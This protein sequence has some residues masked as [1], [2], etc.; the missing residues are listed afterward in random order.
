MIRLT[1][2]VFHD[3]SIWMMGLGLIIGIVFPFFVYWMGIPA[4]YVFKPWFFAV[5]ILAGLIVGGF[6]I[7]L[8]RSVVGTR[9]RILADRMQ[10][11]TERF[12]QVKQGM[13]VGECNPTEC[14]V[15]VDSEDEL[16]FSARA[17]NTLVETLFESL[18]TEDSI[19]RFNQ[20]LGT[21]FEVKDLTEKA[22]SQLM[23]HTGSAAGAV[24]IEKGGAL[25]VTASQGIQDVQSLLSNDHLKGVLRSESRLILSLPKDIQVD[26]VLAKFTPREVIIEPILFKNV[27]L[28]LLILGS[29]DPFGMDAKK[30][31]GL[32]SQNLAMALHNALLFDRLERLAALDSLTGIYNRRFGLTRLHEEF[33][34]TLRMNAPLGMM[35]I[36]LDHFKQVND[37]FG[38]LTG[39]RVLIRLANAAKSVMREG[40][41]LVRYGGEEFLAILPGASWKDV[42]EI[43]DRLRRKIAETSVQHGE[44]VIKVTVSV[45]GVSYPELEV[46]DEMELVD[47]ADKALYRAKES[48]RNCVVMAN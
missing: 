2:K 5:C 12:L 45:G 41:V 40:D 26:G 20:L 17:F 6:N 30:R 18:E 13:D 24:L 25:E 28:G 9:L 11:V 27:M 46:T 14:M 38:H 21:Q 36:D 3:L 1:R 39:D 19:E 47:H 15:T 31:L 42:S 8:A 43:A 35:M 44:D 48:G 32:F 29:A 22:L 23:A 16:G 34:R 37:V 7:L 33:G 4:E 10:H